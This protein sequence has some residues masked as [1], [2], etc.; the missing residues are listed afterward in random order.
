M[1]V[2]RCQLTSDEGGCDEAG[3]R[4]V[5]GK[6]KEHTCTARTQYRKFETNIPRKGTA[7][8]HRNVEIGTEATL[9]LFWK[10]INSNFFAVYPADCIFQAT[11]LVPCTARLDSCCLMW[12]GPTLL[13]VSCPNTRWLPQCSRESKIIKKPQLLYSNYGESIQTIYV[14]HFAIPEENFLLYIFWFGLILK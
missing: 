11:C 2:C 4:L 10:Y 7:R 14:L 8:L 9:F 6:G 5:V 1:C 3:S 12:I 13:R